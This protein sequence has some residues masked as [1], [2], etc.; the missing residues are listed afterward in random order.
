[1]LA[2]EITL[3]LV[4]ALEFEA[5]ELI[6]IGDRP[7]VPLSE[8]QADV[9]GVADRLSES[10]AGRGLQWSDVF[11][12]PAA[13]FTSMT[14][15][16]PDAREREAGR[17]LFRVMLDFAERVGAPGLS[18]LP[19]I[20]WPGESHEESLSRSADEL[21]T[22]AAEARER[23]L[24]FSIEPHMGSLLHTPGEAGRLCEMAPGLELTLDYG[25]YTAMGFSD[26]QIEPLIAHT[27]HFHARAAARGRIQTAL[28]HNT[29]DFE[30]AIDALGRQGYDDFVLIEYLWADLDPRMEQLDILSET[31]LLRDRLRAKLESRPWS[32]PSFSEF[33]PTTEPAQS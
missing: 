3:D 19:G 12:I 26:E 29:I 2:H 14:A 33:D 20:D 30:R 13:D 24:R 17:A 8:V 6:F 15:N 27:R 31:I 5:Y 1:M 10:V 25:H 18:M 7:P 22:R 16:H 21:A 9:A 28:K 4:A 23:G 11:V 32:Y